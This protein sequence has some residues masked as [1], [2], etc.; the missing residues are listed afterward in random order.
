LQSKETRQIDQPA[1][2]LQDSF[3]NRLSNQIGDIFRRIASVLLHVV[4]AF[5]KFVLG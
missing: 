1:I 5:F 3:V 4:V 2:V